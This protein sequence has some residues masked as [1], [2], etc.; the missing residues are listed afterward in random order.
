MVAILAAFGAAFLIWF[1]NDPKPHPPQASCQAPEV[2]AIVET[3]PWHDEI[4]VETYIRS[5]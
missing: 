4:R 1:H 5:D 3:G 2:N